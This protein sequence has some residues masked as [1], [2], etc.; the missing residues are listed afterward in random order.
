[1]EQLNHEQ[2]EKFM[3]YVS[4][5]EELID[6]LRKENERLRLQLSDLKDEVKSIRL[7]K[8]RQY[9]EYQ[10]LLM[11]ENNK[12]KD[13]AEEVERL[14]NMP[15][16]Q[17]CCITEGGNNDIAQIRSFQDPQVGPSDLSDQSTIKMPQK[18]S[19][20]VGTQTEVRFV[21]HA[22]VQ[23]EHDEVRE[24]ER[25]SH[26]CDNGAPRNILLPECCRRDVAGLGGSNTGAANCLFQAL[27]ECLVGMKFSAI[28]QTEG[29]S[30][31]ALHQS[32]GYS[33]SLT[34]VN[35][36]AG[37]DAELLYRV[38]SLG[39]F[40]RVAPEWMREVMMF[41]TSMCPIFFERVSRVIKL[42]P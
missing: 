5:A 39:T 7:S 26:L 2:E 27:V 17:L 37:E 18:H 38:A 3:N 31:S 22:S 12:N 42:H 35:K 4:A 36:P 40:E 34:W 33:F 14:H 29:L 9:V 32:S 11:E 10:K 23:D 41:S 25:D 28:I 24:L 20:H 15:R 16:E 13:L 1:M 6:H 30:V 21:P 19:R 8:E